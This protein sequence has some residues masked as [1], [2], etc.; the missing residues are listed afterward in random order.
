MRRRSPS[1]L[2][3]SRARDASTSVELL[4][5]PLGAVGVQGAAEQTDQKTRPGGPGVRDTRQQDQAEQGEQERGGR[6]GGLP[7][8]DGDGFVVRDQD[9]RGDQRARRVPSRLSAASSAPCSRMTAATYP[10]YRQRCAV[11]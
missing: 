9:R 7:R 10:A 6:V 3:T 5:E 11:R 1:K 4:G 2:S 8:A